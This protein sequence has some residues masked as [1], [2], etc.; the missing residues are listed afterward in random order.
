MEYADNGTLRKYLK[1]NFDNITWKD[2][3]NM[4]H[5]LA[6]AVSCLHNEGIVHSD[7]VKLL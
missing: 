3:L 5:Q 7:L 4:A 1:R 2:K 6:S